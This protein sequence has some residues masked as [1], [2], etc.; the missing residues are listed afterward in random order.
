MLKVPIAEDM[1][2]GPSQQ[3]VF[4]GIEIDSVY[5]GFRLPQ[6]KFLA[7]SDLISSWRKCRKCV[8][9]ELLSLIGSPSFACRVIKPGLSTAPYQSFHISCQTQSP[10]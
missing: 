9:R 5:M 3:L 6:D 10:Y 8:K 1:L 4:L 7:L 2:E